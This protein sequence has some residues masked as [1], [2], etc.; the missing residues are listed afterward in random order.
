VAKPKTHPPQGFAGGETIRNLM[1]N[2][3]RALDQ[4]PAEVEKLQRLIIS[5]LHEKFPK[6]TDAPQHELFYVLEPAVRA[7]IERSKTH[8]AAVAAILS[9]YEA[10]PTNEQIQVARPPH[11]QSI[12]AAIVVGLIIAA[13]IVGVIIIYLAAKYD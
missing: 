9:R 5:V 11:H 1:V 7:R 10:L 4:S 2:V 6:A 13:V 12:I 8:N 3:S